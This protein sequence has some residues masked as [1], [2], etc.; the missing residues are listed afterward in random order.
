MDTLYECA[1]AC[2]AKDSGAQHVC[3]RKCYKHKTHPLRHARQGVC[4]VIVVI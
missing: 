4:D 3:M 1:S 2:P